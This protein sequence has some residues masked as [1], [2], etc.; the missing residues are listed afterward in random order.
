MHLKHLL[1]ILLVMANGCTLAASSHSLA[2]SSSLN[3]VFRR[4]NPSVVEIAGIRH[5]ARGEDSDPHSVLG[6]GVV[7]SKEGQVLTAAHVVQAAETILVRFLD[8]ETA[9]ASVVSSA[10][11]ADVA[12]LQLE[13]VTSN[14]TP[15]VLGNSDTAEVGDKV[16][17]IGAPYGI[18]HTMTVGHISGRRQSQSP[19][20]TM[21]PFEF[22]QT[23]AAINQGNSGGPMLDMEGNIIGIVSRILSRSGGSEGLGFAV[24][25]NSA[26]RLLLEGDSVWIGFD[27]I[28]IAGNLAQALNVPQEAG[29]LVQK[30]APNS[31]AAR[32]GLQPGRIQAGLG[33]RK[34]L[35]GGDVILDIQGITIEPSTRNICALD[36]VVGGFTSESRITM[37]VLRK[38]RTVKLDNQP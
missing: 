32:M 5:Q 34:M 3:H 14:L 11:Q 6:S 36:N 4:V 38:G 12:L 13:S 29:L 2:Q 24:G 15:A 28:L 23:D 10:T 7:I 22:L 30:V 9:R 8:G 21:T 16:L 37:T 26:R 35:L 19:C 1:V 33:D 17:V 20:P 18:R 31:L 25:I 27:A